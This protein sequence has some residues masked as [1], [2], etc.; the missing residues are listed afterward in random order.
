MPEF[1]YSG[2]DAG[3]GKIKGTLAAVSKT[4]AMD[5]LAG[6]NVFVTQLD[7]SLAGSG[8]GK[9]LRLP[10]FQR[11]SP[12]ELTLMI[13]RLATMVGSDIP[14]AECLKALSVQVESP[15]LRAVLSEVRDDVQH[16]LSF[17]AALSTAFFIAPDAFESRQ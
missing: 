7:E 17:S 16:G 5:E 2:V 11:I 15:A 9:E 6:Q 12:A 10:V 4:A 1:S 3:G 13:R 14:L 8:G